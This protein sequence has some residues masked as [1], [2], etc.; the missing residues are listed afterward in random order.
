MTETDTL[1][2]RAEPGARVERR[3]RRTLRRR[4]FLAGPAVILAII[5][6]AV[7]IARLG[8]GSSPAPRSLGGAAEGGQVTYLL[9]GARSDDDGLWPSSLER[10][11]GKP[12]PLQKPCMIKAF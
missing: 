5:V 10:A 11:R 9:I 4:T 7:G 1:T 6:G 3:R 8:G 2:H 12:Q